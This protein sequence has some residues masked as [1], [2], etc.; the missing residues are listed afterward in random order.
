MAFKVE[1][2]LLITGAT[3]YVTVD[4][5]DTFF[6]D[7]SDSVWAAATEANKEAALIRASSYMQARY[8]MQWKGSRVDAL[9]ALDWPRRG[10]DI[11]DYFDPFYS[12]PF[13]PTQFINSY[14]YPITTIPE[15]V[16]Q[17]QML[18][19][20]EVLDDSSNPVNTLQD[21]LERLTKREKVGSIEV[22]YMDS[23]QGGAGT[24]LKRYWEAENLL[25]PLLRRTRLTGGTIVRG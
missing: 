3:S 13:A 7:R 25:T 23:T 10:V 24:R 22:E 12:N 6:E 4:A 2:G 9:Q 17:A 1:T 14:F 20:R 19:A 5:A 16:K 8:R 21:N 18:L 11:P 15:Q